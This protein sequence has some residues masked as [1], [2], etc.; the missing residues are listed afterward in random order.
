VH[1]AGR[2]AAYGALAGEA[3]GFDPGQVALKARRDWTLIGTAAPRR[4]VPAKVDGSAVF[5][6]DVRLPEML[7]A[8]V[9]MCPELGG[10]VG[11]LDSKAALAMPRVH[12]VVALPAAAGA[13]AGFAVIA[14]SWWHAER[15]AAGAKAFATICAVCHQPTGVGN[16]AMGSPNLTDDIW[17]HGGRRED[18]QN[19]IRNGLLSQMPAHS[20]FLD[21]EQ[22]HLVALYVYSLS[23]REEAA[24]R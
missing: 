16:P 21:P 6:I 23:H 20:A 24:G 3:A 15:A 17:L 2:Q 10:G 9:R 7:H 19:A 14:D 5:G 8:A 11:T 12:Q 22:I 13:S 18:I 4:D 1:A